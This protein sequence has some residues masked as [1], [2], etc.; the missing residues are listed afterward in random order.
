MAFIKYLSYRRGAIVVRV[1]APKWID[2]VSILL[3]SHIKDS[4][5]RY[6]QISYLAI[7]TKGIV[8]YDR[9][10]VKTTANHQQPDCYDSEKQR[11]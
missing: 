11:S 7:S 3:S 9:Q 8:L 2:V 6:L 4:N 5:K 1:S 10:A